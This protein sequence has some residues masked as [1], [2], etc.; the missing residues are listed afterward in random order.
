MENVKT[1]V[2][3]LI[4]IFIV[5]AL[6]SVIFSSGDLGNQLIHNSNDKEFNSFTFTLKDTLSITY[7]FSGAL[8]AP[9]YEFVFYP[10][11]QRQ[12]PCI[13]SYQW[14]LYAGAVLQ[15]ARLTALM[16]IDLT[17][18]HSY[19]KHNN[20]TT[21]QCIFAEKSGILSSNFDIKW[22]ILPR[23]LNSV[24][25]ITTATG[26]L[27]F[28]CSQ[29][30]YPMRGLLFGAMHGSLV[31]CS[32]AG[33]GILQPFRKQSVRA[34]STGMISCEFWYLLLTLL[35]VILE[36]MMLCILM[37]WYKRRK[38]DDI[39]PNEQIFAERYYTKY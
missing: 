33:Y 3:S 37:K 23:A 4:V 34:W 21:L 26:V 35:I 9:I 18:R 29:A 22:M 25:I 17:A 19:I 16:A 24:S 11:L 15:L 10:L 6:S 12:L 7:Y 39:L 20:N 28:V 1:F 5:S 32:V 27:E 30:P 38:R 13:Q 31:V 14:K 8:L 36:L 2:R